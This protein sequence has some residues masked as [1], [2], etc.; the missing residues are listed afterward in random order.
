MAS[1]KNLGITNENINKMS[2]KGI[3][4]LTTSSNKSRLLNIKRTEVRTLIIIRT[5]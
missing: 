2:R 5:G 1:S 4:L 3:F